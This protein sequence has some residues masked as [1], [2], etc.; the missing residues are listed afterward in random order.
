[1]IFL[2][3]GHGIDIVENSRIEFNNMDFAYRYMTRDEIKQLS[4]LNNDYEKRMFMIGIWALKESIIKAMNHTIIFSQISIIMT[5]EAPICQ[6]NGYKLFLTLSY[7]HNYTIAS[8]IS[9]KL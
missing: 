4:K 1:M 7:E 3:F 5:N 8:C 6:I 2:P 9:Y